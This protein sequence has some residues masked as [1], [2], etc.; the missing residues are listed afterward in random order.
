[1]LRILSERAIEKQK[2]IDPCF[3]DYSKPFNTVRHEPLINLLKAIDVDSHGVQLLAN[4]YWKQK[5]AVC[6]NGEISEWMSIKQ[7]ERQGCVASPHLLAMCTEMIMISLEDKEGF[8]IGGRVINNFRYAVDSVIV[9]EAEHELL[10]L[11]GIV[12]QESEHRGLFLN[13]A[14]SYTMVF[15]KSSYIPTCQIK[16][17]GKPLK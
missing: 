6:H 15:N 5:A 3:F 14:K 16:V 11:M 8:R 17:H 12:V 9:S 1:M 4:L 2:D 10:H 13:I 7:G